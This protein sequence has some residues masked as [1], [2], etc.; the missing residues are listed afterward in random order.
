[1]GN[2][3]LMGGTIMTQQAPSV[4]MMRTN[5]ESPV[6]RLNE[7]LDAHV[8]PY[9]V[10]FL[11][12]RVVILLTLCLLVPLIVWASNTVVVLLA[13]SYLNVM[14]VVVS[15]TVLLYSTLSEARDRAAAERREQI[16]AAHQKSVEARAEADHERIQEIYQHI[17]DLHDQTISQINES[18]DNIQKI[19]IDHLEVNQAEDHEHVE[20]MH[21]AVLASLDAHKEELDN[22]RRLLRSSGP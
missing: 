16:A 11:T 14:S 9:P 17:V 3:M 1:M 15:S 8:L 21:R 10:K 6:E 7:F 2:I 5:R 4:P 12:N 19:L 20:E 13:N 18:L 22:L